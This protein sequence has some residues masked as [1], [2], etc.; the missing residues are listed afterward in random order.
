MTK[1]T[2]NVVLAIVGAV[3]LGCLGTGALVVGFGV[4]AA[5]Q[6]GGDTSWSEDSVPERELPRLYGVRLPV[7]PLVY[8]SRQQGFQDGFWEVLV[9]LP[10]GSAE[11]LLGA[12]RL[13]RGAAAT[14]VSV[15]VSELI[16]SLDPAAPALTATSVELYEA[17][18]PDGGPLNLHRRAV[19]LEGPGA[20][21][22]YL[23]AFEA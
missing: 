16:R 2:R 20:V 10:P 23:E 9:K 8:R 14:H 3:V 11:A 6:F 4:F 18:Q 17:L 5:S 19:L 7:K 13:Q 21:W 1:S 15:E 12:N 22:L